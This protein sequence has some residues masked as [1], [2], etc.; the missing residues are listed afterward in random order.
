[1]EQTFCTGRDSLEDD[2]HRTI[3]TE[4]KIQEVASLMR[5][6][7]SQIVDEVA[8]AIRISHGTFHKILSYYLNMSHFPSILTQ[9][10]RDDHMSTC[11]D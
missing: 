9:D 3:R 4:L 2:E 10:Q 1:V 7:G 5:A 8:A 11:S 6:H